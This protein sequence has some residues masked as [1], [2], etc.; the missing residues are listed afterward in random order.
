MALEHGLLVVKKV[1]KNKEPRIQIRIGEDLFNPSR[2]EVSQSL[3]DHLDKF[4]DQ[5]VEFER[6]GGQPKQ[7]REV[8]GSFVPPRRQESESRPRDARGSA[9]GPQGRK[10]E[11]CT[12]QQQSHDFHNPYNFAPAPPRNTSHGDLG[13]HR[14]VDQDTFHPDRYSGRIRVRMT[15]ETPLLLPDTESVRERST[16][17]KTCSLLVGLDGKPLIPA[18]SVRGMLRSAYEAITNSRFGKFSESHRQKLKYREQCK[19]YKKVDFKVSPWDLL[20]ESLKPPTTI[21][22]LSLPTGSSD[23]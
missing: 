9:L 10:Q 22:Q 19:P 1:G 14:P 5:K 18:S 8:N 2:G 20:H 12:E 6:I 15:A 4:S 16:G 13:D 21:E 3:L 17:H 7:I 11:E 23:G